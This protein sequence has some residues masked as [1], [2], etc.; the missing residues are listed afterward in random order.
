MLKFLKKSAAVMAVGA[1][2]LL[3]GCG[4]KMPFTEKKPDLN[5]PY[6]VSAQ[7]KCDRLKMKADITRAAAQDWKFQFTEPKQLN[8]I[9]LSYDSEGLSASLGGLSFTADENAEYAM[10]PEIISG[11]LDALSALGTEGFVNENEKLTANIAFDGKPVTVTLDAETGN[12]VSLNCPHYQLA[13]TF[14]EQKPY[15]VAADDNANT[16]LPDTSSETAS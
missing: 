12:L 7:I 10:I 9:E 11:T 8:G 2:L 16:S 6:T 3:S 15:T 14:T 4:M 13:V 1:T 5:T